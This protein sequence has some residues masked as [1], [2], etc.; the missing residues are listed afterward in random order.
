[1]SDHP[2]AA[3]TE[4][5]GDNIAMPEADFG[6]RTAVD[7]TAADVQA[8]TEFLTTRINAIINDES[9][10]F[11]SESYRVAA[12]LEFPVRTA[13]LAL[14]TDLAQRAATADLGSFDDRQTVERITATW[15]QLM[16]MVGPWEGMIGYDHDRWRPASPFP[17]DDAETDQP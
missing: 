1:M 13:A 5:S 6:E 2:N 11:D 16:D 4:P 14:W 17:W 15:N 7:L 10:P 8:V 9:I 3:P 12:S